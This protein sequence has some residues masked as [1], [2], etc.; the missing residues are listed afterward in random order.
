MDRP[1]FGSR[2]IDY[3][4]EKPIMSGLNKSSDCRH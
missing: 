1:E 3:A 2:D 4:S